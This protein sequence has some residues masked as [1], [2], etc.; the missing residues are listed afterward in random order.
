MDVQELYNTIYD[1]AN[2]AGWKTPV[3]FECDG[4]IYEAK[5]APIQ[6]RFNEERKIIIISAPNAEA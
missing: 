4:E 1:L 6:V 2:Y 5:N 3:V